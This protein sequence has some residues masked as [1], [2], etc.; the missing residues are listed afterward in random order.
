MS[1]DKF[2]KQL[3]ANYKSAKQFQS[4]NKPLKKKHRFKS[5]DQINV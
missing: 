1:Q 2:L 5:A 3:G 4:N